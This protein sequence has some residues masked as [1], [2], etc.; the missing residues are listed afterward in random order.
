MKLQAGNVSAVK[1]F[2]FQVILDGTTAAISE[3]RDSDNE[4]EAGAIHVYGIDEC[5]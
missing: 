5:L 4:N 1:E 2:A 3:D